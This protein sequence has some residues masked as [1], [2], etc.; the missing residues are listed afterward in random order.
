LKGNSYKSSLTSVYAHD[1]RIESFDTW[2][3]REAERSLGQDAGPEIA[4]GATAAPLV[5]LSESAFTDA[6]RRALRDYTRPVCRRCFVNRSS[7][8]TPP[9]A[10]RSSTARCTARR[11]RVTDW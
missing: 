11:R 2:W 9:I 8:S 7:G 3:E 4:A 6:V 5:G 10:T 1:W